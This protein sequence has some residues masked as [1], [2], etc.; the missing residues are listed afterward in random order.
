MSLD[1]TLLADFAAA[2]YL[3]LLRDADQARLRD[4][5]LRG[6]LRAQTVDGQVVAFPLASNTQLLWYRKSVARRA[7]L[8]LSRPLTWR[9]L[10]AAAESAR[11]TVQVQAAQYEGYTVWLNSLIEGAGGDILEPDSRPGRAMAQVVHGLATSSAGD[12]DLDST[13]E[14]ET[15]ERF[16]AGDAGF[17]VNWPYILHG[18]WRDDAAWDQ[19]GLGWDRYPRSVSGRPA[20]PPL[21]DVGLAVADVSEHR[22]LAMKAARCLSTREHQIDFMLSYGWPSGLASVSDDPIIREAYPMAD[23]LRTSLQSGAPRPET[24]NYWEVSSALRGVLWP[25]DQVDPQSTPREAQRAVD[26]ALGAVIG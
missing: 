20:R 13:T 8:E 4:T 12:P 9:E 14:L 16:F 3:S 2:G 26:A 18:P 22:R 17:M 11:T 1:T 23:L 5:M 7:E 15:H 6:P 10:I 21:A 19:D 24:S 25:P